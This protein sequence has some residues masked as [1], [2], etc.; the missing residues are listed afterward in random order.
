MNYLK[1]YNTCIINTKP[2]H[3]SLIHSVIVQLKTPRGLTLE[4]GQHQLAEYMATEVV[5]F[6]PIMEEYLK[7]YCILYNAYVKGIYCGKMWV[8]QYMIGA[9]SRML[10]IK[11]TVIS[12]YYADVW[13]VFHKSALPD[14][15]VLSNWGDFGTK[16]AV[17]HFTATHGSDNVWRYVGSDINVGELR[18]HY[19]ESDGTAC[20]INVFEATEKR[21]MA[22]K[23]RK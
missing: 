7:K 22:M 13:N 14:V 18:Y 12:P 11:I 10:N 4:I 16:S 3:N 1:Y 19:R 15:A 8:D 9:L 23:A 2:D 5:F 17:T 21:K 6:F 20:S